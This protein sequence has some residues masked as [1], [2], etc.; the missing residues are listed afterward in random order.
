MRILVLRWWTVD[1]QCSRVVE[2]R[3]LGGDVLWLPLLPSPERLP[4]LLIGD[5]L[6]EHRN[7]DAKRRSVLLVLGERVGAYVALLPEARR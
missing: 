5:S 6:A 1:L 2:D 7:L 3:R 4:S